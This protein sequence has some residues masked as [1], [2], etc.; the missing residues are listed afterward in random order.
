MK[1]AQ[2]YRRFKSLFRSVKDYFV[3]EEP[4]DKARRTMKEATEALN[5]TI[6]QRMALEHEYR[7]G[8]LDAEARQWCEQNIGCLREAERAMT[9]NLCVLREQY[10]KLAL[11]DLF[12]KTL[13]DPSAGCFQEAHTALMEL[14]AAVEA[15]QTLQSLPMLLDAPSSSPAREQDKP[16]MVNGESSLEAKTIEVEERN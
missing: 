2:F 10:R 9:E 6:Y 8:S 4:R 16:A 5:K 3:E 14:K 7:S 1:K 11:Q 15:E 13:S 12:Y